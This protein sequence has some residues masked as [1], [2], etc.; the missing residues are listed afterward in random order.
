MSYIEIRR[1]VRQ[2]SFWCYVT[3]GQT[4]CR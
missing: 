3:D 1:T 2:P 4:S